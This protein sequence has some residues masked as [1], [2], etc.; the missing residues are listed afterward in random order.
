VVIVS[1]LSPG[2][3]VEVSTFALEKSQGGSGLVPGIVWDKSRI[4]EIL[5]CSDSCTGDEGGTGMASVGLAR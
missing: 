5:K 1:L 2:C 3:D 4:V